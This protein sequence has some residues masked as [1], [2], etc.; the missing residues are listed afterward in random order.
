MRKHPL[1]F[2]Q[3][4]VVGI[5]MQVSIVEKKSLDFRDVEKGYLADSWNG[6]HE[7]GGWGGEAQKLNSQFRSP[8]G[9]KQ[10]E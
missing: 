9:K 2:S 4:K 6:I 8:K 10:N 3:G 7:Y 1:Q 5:Y